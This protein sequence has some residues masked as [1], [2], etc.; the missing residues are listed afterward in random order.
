MQPLKYVL[1]ESKGSFR[2]QLV[3]THQEIMWINR[4][5]ELYR[6]YSLQAM[7]TSP[8]PVLAGSGSSKPIWCSS[9]MRI[10]AIIPEV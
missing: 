8:V 7:A 2:F 9:R 6:S 3:E 1:L 4:S 5:A 10:S